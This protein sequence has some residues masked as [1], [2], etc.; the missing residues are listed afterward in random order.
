[1]T[2]EKKIFFSLALPSR[3]LSY[4]KI[5]NFIF[6]CLL[7]VVK[8]LPARSFFCYFAAKLVYYSL[9]VDEKEK[10]HIS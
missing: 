7:I 4:T 10:K 9:F 1:M 2:N 8:L 6:F 3:I 5:Y